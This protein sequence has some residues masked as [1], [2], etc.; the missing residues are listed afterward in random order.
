PERVPTGGQFLTESRGWLE[1]QKARLLRVVPPR[2]VRSSPVLESFALEAQLGSQK[3]WMDYHVTR[4]AT[5]GATV[6]ARL[7]ADLAAAQKEVE[8]IARSLEVTRR[9]GSKR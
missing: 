8:G 3:V 1:K 6:A 5:G 7:V 2:T 9:V 4:Q